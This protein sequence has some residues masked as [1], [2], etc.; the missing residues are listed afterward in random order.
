MRTLTL[1]KLAQSGPVSIQSMNIMVRLSTS[2]LRSV[3]IKEISIW[4]YEIEMAVRLLKLKAN[5]HLFLIESLSLA[6]KV[7][8]VGLPF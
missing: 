8:V 3:P 1:L 4:R 2:K 7:P 6:H 5:S